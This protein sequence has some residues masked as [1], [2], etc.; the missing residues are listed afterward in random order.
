MSTF[1]VFLYLQNRYL[2]DISCTYLLNRA[3]KRHDTSHLFLQ[4]IQGNYL[5]SFAVD[6]ILSCFKLSNVFLAKIEVKI[7]LLKSSFALNSAHID[8]LCTLLNLEFPKLKLSKVQF[9]YILFCFRNTQYKFLHSFT[10]RKVKNIETMRN[11]N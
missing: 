3:G 10:D 11:F 5:K 9:V 8:A 1:I 7:W 2:L 6:V 4:I